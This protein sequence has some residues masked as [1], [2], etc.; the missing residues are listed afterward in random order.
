MVKISGKQVKWDLIR[1]F[2]SLFRLW[3]FYIGNMVKFGHGPFCY[4][5][6][7]MR[8][9][10]KAFY[11]ACLHAG[12]AHIAAKTVNLPGLFLWFYHECLAR[13]LLLA[14]PARNALT[15]IDYHVSPGQWCYLCGFYWIHKCRRLSKDTPCHG[16][17]HLKKSHFFHLSEHPI[18]GSIECTI[19]GTSASSQPFNIATRGGIFVK[20]GVLTRDLARFFVPLPFT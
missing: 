14:D 4:R 12:I 9:H 5:L 20:V 8:I 10:G 18:H 13:A 16:P 17:G 11:R 3:W 6:D 1:T 2:R 19:T 15:H 7:I